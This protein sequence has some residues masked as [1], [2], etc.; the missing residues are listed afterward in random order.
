MLID[1]NTWIGHWPFRRLR[2]A[3]AAGLLK[4]MDRVGIDTAVVADVSAVLYRDSHAATQDLA[5]AVRRHRD[6][7]LPVATL[8]G[9]ASVRPVRLLW[10][11]YLGGMLLLTAGM[12]A[13]RHLP[14]A[15]GGAVTVAA[16]AIYLWLLIGNLRGGRAMPAVAAHAWAAIAALAVLALL[17][18]VLIVNQE[19]GFLPDAGRAAA[20]HMLVAGYGFMGLFALG[21]SYVLV[22]MFVLAPAPAVRPALASLALAV[23]GLGLGAGGAWHGRDGLA[24]AGGVAGL[25]AAALYL[26]LMRQT[27]RQRMRKRL[28]PEFT[29]LRIA[30]VLLPISLLAAIAWALDLM[31]EDGPVLVGLLLLPGWLLTFLLAILQR[32]VPF[33]ASMHAARAVKRA[34]PTV[35]ALTARGPLAV[36][37]YCHLAALALLLAGALLAETWLIRLAALSGIAGALA[38]ALFFVRAMLK[39]AAVLRP[40]IAT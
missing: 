1:I 14:M 26:W 36:H 25:L 3:T 18:L 13:A 4:H 11:L 28:G 8:Q 32:I 37:F 20:T 34:P 10:W 22:P 38:F 16:L 30:W 31:P 17:G 40:A 2:R 7:L 21:F 12:G 19:H 29:L 9:F 35:S 15:A 5:S 27:L 23:L 33:L 24:A 6:R 39:L